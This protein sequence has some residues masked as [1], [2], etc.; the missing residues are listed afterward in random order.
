[1][2]MVFPLQLTSHATVMVDHIP[3]ML[4]YAF[5]P[6]VRLSFLLEFPPNFFKSERSAHSSM[7][8]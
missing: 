7:A 8:N 2:N 4:S 5:T 1:M 3:C 6:L